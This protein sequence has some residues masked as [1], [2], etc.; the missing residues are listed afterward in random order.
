VSWSLTRMPHWCASTAQRRFSRAAF[1]AH[2][3]VTCWPRCNARHD[4][5]QLLPLPQS[6]QPVRSHRHVAAGAACCDVLRRPARPPGKVTRQRPVNA[7]TPACLLQLLVCRSGAWHPAVRCQ[8]SHARATS[9]PQCWLALPGTAA[10]RLCVCVAS[11]RRQGCSQ[12]T[13][14][15]LIVSLDNVSTWPNVLLHPC[16]LPAPATHATPNTLGKCLAPFTHDTTTCPLTRPVTCIKAL[17]P[18]PPVRC[19]G[20]AAV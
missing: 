5:S 2:G 7:N 16:P 12:P 15:W 1:P 3:F 13:A 9:R 4:A 17:N 6:S 14:A 11:S 20:P 10:C 18:T 19:W 8:R